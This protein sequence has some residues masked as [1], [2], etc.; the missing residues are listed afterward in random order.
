M[1][2]RSAETGVASSA[3]VAH[4]PGAVRR[5][6]KPISRGFVLSRDAEMNYV[7]ADLRRLLYTAG[8][9]FLVMIALLL[10]LD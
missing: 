9:L 5:S 8:V 7:R 4:A 10:I 1:E 2:I 6:V 3:H